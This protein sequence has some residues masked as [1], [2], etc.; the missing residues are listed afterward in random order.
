MHLRKEN[1]IIVIIEVA[2]LISFTLESV[3]EALSATKQKSSHGDSRR[4][5]DAYY[6]ATQEPSHSTYSLSTTCLCSSS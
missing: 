3:A 1:K 4:I 5:S 6:S 2:E